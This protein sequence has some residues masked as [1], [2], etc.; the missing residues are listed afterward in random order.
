MSFQ[1]STEWMYRVD[2][3]VT[4]DVRLFHALAA[5]TRNVYE[6]VYIE[7]RILAPY[8]IFVFLRLTYVRIKL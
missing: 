6:Y 8:L 5:A 7:C 3:A 2:A 1:G 4:V